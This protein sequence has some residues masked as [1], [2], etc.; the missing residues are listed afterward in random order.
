MHGFSGTLVVEE[1]VVTGI[2]TE[3]TGPEL[4]SL[5]QNYPNPFSS[6]TSIS[7]TIP[8]TERVT[9]KVYDL[10]GRERLTVT[11]GLYSAGRHEVTFGARDLASGLYF[12][13]I[14]AGNFTRT[15]TLII[16]R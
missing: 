9:L 4:A 13:R 12:Y 10:L 8:R 5:S 3:E 6:F 2:E 14:Q 1:A 15:K 7:Y 16:E 11:E